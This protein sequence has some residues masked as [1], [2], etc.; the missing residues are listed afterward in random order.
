[1]SAPLIPLVEPLLIGY[2]CG[3]IPFGLI[4]TKAFTNTDI[5]TIGS[6]NIGATNVLRTGNKKL[7]AL[8]LLLDALKAALPIIIFHFISF[9]G[10]FGHTSFVAAALGAT[11]GHCFPIW[12]KFK[13]GKG[14]ATALGGLLAAVPY[15]GLAACAAW[16]ITAK[17]TKISSQSSLNSLVAA[18]IVTFLMYDVFSCFMCTMIAV[19]VFRRHKENI[20]RL[21]NGTEPKIGA[22]KKEEEKEGHAGS[23]S[24]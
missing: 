18:S 6:G 13:G 8:T 3:S 4:L 5:R 22:K 20:K 7:A 11:L 2:I 24:Q 9:S 10:P 12:L 23:V 16:L 1:M 17:I 14:V 21:R 19:T 15:A